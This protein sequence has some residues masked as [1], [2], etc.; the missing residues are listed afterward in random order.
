MKKWK[1]NKMKK[2]EEEKNK[3]K[4]KRV[5]VQVQICEFLA[6]M[7]QLLE[8]YVCQL[9]AACEVEVCDVRAV[10]CD[11]LH[12]AQDTK[13]VGILFVTAEGKTTWEPR[14]RLCQLV[15]LRW[16]NLHVQP[17]EYV[18]FLHHKILNTAKQRLFP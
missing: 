1:A 17:L 14:I 7:G 6:P 18:L 16:Q 13:A 12:R 4:P 8:C 3:K 5:H 9:F 15:G 2:L 11:C 10:L